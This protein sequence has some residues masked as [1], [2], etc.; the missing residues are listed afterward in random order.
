M[1]EWN[2]FDI[3]RIIRACLH[4]KN[5]P[6]HEV[7]PGEI[8]HSSIPLSTRVNFL[9]LIFCVHEYGF[10]AYGVF[11]LNADPEDE[12]AMNRTAEF[13]HRAN[14]GLPKGNFELDYRD[15]EVRYKILEMIRN[16]RDLRKDIVWECTG[17][18]GAM[19]SRYAPG[20]LQVMSGQREPRE[21]IDICERGEEEE[22]VVDPTTSFEERCRRRAEE[23]RKNGFLSPE[24]GDNESN[25][26]DDPDED[27]DD[28]PDVITDESEWDENDPETAELHELANDA[29]REQMLNQIEDMIQELMEKEREAERERQQSRE[30][31]EEATFCDF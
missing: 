12:N 23:A 2:V 25:E 4:E 10:N 22:P 30:V 18:I 31:P 13:L 3:T 5:L 15:G 6:C 24:C 17:C 8:I 21:A 1:S 27:E 26:C 7:K 28:G 19:M 20:L 16:R 14:Y 9:R 11:P 29:R